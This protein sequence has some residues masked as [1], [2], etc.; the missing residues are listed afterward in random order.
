M[1]QTTTISALFLA[2]L[3]LG[4]CQGD[5]PAPDLTGQGGASSVPAAARLYVAGG[6]AGGDLVAGGAAPRYFEPGDESGPSVQGTCYAD[7]VQA[8]LYTAETERALSNLARVNYPDNSD[9]D[10]E[11]ILTAETEIMGLDRYAELPFSTT[12]TS[13]NREKFIQADALAYTQADAGRF[14]VDTASTKRADLSLALTDG[15]LAPELYFGEA[16]VT[17]STRGEFNEEHNTFYFT[18]SNY[19]QYP[20]QWNPTGTETISA[21]LKGRIY[22]I[23]GQVNL[24][25]TEV[26]TDVVRQ[27]ELL[28]THYPMR[29]GLGGTHGTYYPVKAVTSATDTRGDQPVVLGSVDYDQAAGDQAA[30]MSAFV[31]PSEVGM[32]LSLR[33]TYRD[34]LLADDGM[35]Y[36]EKTFPLRP[37]HSY[38]LTGTDAA[39]YSPASAD[40]RSDEGLYV[41]DGRQDKYCFYTYANVRVNLSGVFANVAAET[42]EVQITINVEPNFEEEH[43][44]DII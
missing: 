40:L 33:V 31:L 43:D 41:Y 24:N 44:Y 32:E 4:G 37:G 8:F 16:R 6:R 23:V 13:D 15:S 19:A 25:M 38:S 5:E 1:K 7:H 30:A 3:V 22:R 20:S 12:C 35:R 21:R 28:A 27:V 17:A 18:N 9:Y 39:V 34:S 11:A 29:I 10:R 14:T 42:G 2:A 26:P 36:L